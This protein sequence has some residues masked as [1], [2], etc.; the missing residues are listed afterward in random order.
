MMERSCW[1]CKHRTTTVNIDG[2]F[3]HYCKLHDKLTKDDY[4]CPWF[5]EEEDE[6]VVFDEEETFTEID[7]L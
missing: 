3:Y 6:E 7:D 4:V 5:E 1:N 2:I